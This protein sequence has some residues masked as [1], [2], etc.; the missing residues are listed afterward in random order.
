MSTLNL[1][2]ENL[3]K[4]SNLPPQ[5]KTKL[6]QEPF[7]S[8]IKDILSEEISLPSKYLASI[9][10]TAFKS[11]ITHPNLQRTVR[12]QALLHTL[13]HL[14]SRLSC[15]SSG[16]FYHLL[17]ADLPNV[18]NHGAVNL[19]FLKSAHLI[20]Y[21]IHHFDKNYI[22]TIQAAL[23]HIFQKNEFLLKYLEDHA[24][25]A[26][27]FFH[28]ITPLLSLNWLNN[29]IPSFLYSFIIAIHNY[30]NSKQEL[31]ICLMERHLKIAYLLF[32]A[33]IPY[34]KTILLEIGSIE[35]ILFHYDALISEAQ[36]K[37]KSSELLP[38]QEKAFQLILCS[39]ITLE[40]KIQLL[41]DYYPSIVKV[42]HSHLKTL[43][44][45]LYDSNLQ[46]QVSFKDGEELLNFFYTLSQNKTSV[47]SDNLTLSPF[48]N[49]QL[50]QMSEKFA[51][52]ESSLVGF[53]LPQPQLG[54]SPLGVITT[55]Q[56]SNMPL[57][58]IE[59]ESSNTTAC[60]TT[61][62]FMHKR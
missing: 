30:S 25:N 58:N 59:S 7:I 57:I 18:S 8:I 36:N 20:Y 27:L 52:F 56:I 54:A 3:I 19:N 21:L 11:F 41:T 12:Y 61:P 45:Y 10:N 55:H 60:T 49:Y 47:F 26:Y 43:V 33:Y 53:N 38:N 22:A 28:A 23:K 2:A 42:S 9:S 40:Q 15:D 24:A 37:S 17:R 46:K 4:E 35:D 31:F 32:Q 39:P 16:A 5:S 14:Q 29:N 50:H 51:E 44:T 62:G 13:H 34:S 1:S 48:I 6:L